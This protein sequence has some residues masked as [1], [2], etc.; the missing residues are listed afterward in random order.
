MSQKEIAFKIEEIM[1]DTEKVCSVQSALFAAYYCQDE[2][3]IEAFEGTFILMQ[4]ITSDI[5]QRLTELT[6]NIF[7]YLKGSE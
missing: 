3:A 2:Y 7:S 6:S 4:G 5:L 1:N